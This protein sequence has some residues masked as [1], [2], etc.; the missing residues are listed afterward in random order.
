MFRNF[1]S[2]QLDN[3]HVHN[4]EIWR[5]N[6]ECDDLN[7][8]SDVLAQH[9]TSSHNKTHSLTFISKYIVPS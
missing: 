7:A 5:C 9:V 6:I 3:Y 2:P 8:T 1:F 4:V